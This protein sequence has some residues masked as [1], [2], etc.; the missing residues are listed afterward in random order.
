MKFNHSLEIDELA[1]DPGL[2]LEGILEIEFSYGGENSEP[3]IGEL[4]DNYLLFDD[5]L[6]KEIKRQEQ[7]DL[8]NLYPERIP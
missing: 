1:E 5:Y 8:N 6:Q 2:E 3:L 4:P 7:E